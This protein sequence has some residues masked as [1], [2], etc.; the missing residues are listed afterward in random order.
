[1]IK[2]FM[3]NFTLKESMNKVAMAL[4]VLEL[5]LKEWEPISVGD[6]FAIIERKT[7]AQLG[8]GKNLKSAIL[9]ARDNEM[10]KLNMLPREKR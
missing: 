9:K 5:N 3:L 7:K 2:F 10:R 1:M 8:I 4:T 6:R